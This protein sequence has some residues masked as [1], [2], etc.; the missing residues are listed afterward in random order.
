[1]TTRPYFATTAPGLELLTARELESLGIEAA[2]ESGG[3]GFGGG[4]AGL[5]A[6]SLHLR[7]ASRLLARAAV[8]R[9]TAFW[10]LE[11]RAR[12]VAWSRF[13]T[14][15]PVRLR[16]TSKRSKLYHENAIAERLLSAIAAA[17]GAK[18][19]QTDIG[20]PGDVDAGDESDGGDDAE[21]Q[22]IVV[23]VHRDSF[24]ISAD[25]SGELL[26]RRGYRRALAR[27]P[28]RETLAAAILL[29]AGWDGETPLLDPF[30]GSGTIPVEAA[31][32]ARRIPP[33]LAAADRR[34]RPHAFMRWPDFDAEVWSRIVDAARERI[35][36]AAEVAIIGSDR[37]AGAIAAAVSN[38]TRAGVIGDIAFRN[39]AL[40][41]L[42]T[43]PGG[44]GLLATNP[45]YGARIGR[46]DPLRD[47]YAALGHVAR[48]HLPGWQIA[49]LSA[50][51]R[52]GAQ[53]GIPL[54]TLLRTRNGGIEVRIEKG[55]V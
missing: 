50:D 32:L 11:K 14:A 15:G 43:P 12:E 27:A 25:A 46:A 17:T 4:R 24:T 26:H 44:P 6:A 1:M 23:R 52:L 37:D 55:Q 40:S 16:V 28:M 29:A 53:I 45:P 41:H 21:A 54:E 38:A 9:A 47:L 30:C 8:F 5:Y 51:R 10:E 39:L 42:E 35:L 22:L 2:V 20:R 36:P 19:T 48:E 13:L 7:T 18:P 3:V 33:G 31:L 34:P 49:L